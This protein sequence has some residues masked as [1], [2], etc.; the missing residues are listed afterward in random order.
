MTVLSEDQFD[1]AWTDDSDYALLK[2]VARNRGGSVATDLIIQFKEDNPDAISTVKSLYLNVI[3]ADIDFW[4]NQL[5]IKYVF[6]IPHSGTDVLNTSCEAVAS[7]LDNKFE[8]IHHIKHGI[9]RTTDVT[10]SAQTRNRPT[11]TDQQRSLAFNV[12]PF[13]RFYGGKILLIDDVV[14]LGATST[15]CKAILNTE[16]PKAIVYGFFLGRTVQR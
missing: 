10:K 5:N 15:A 2:Y 11:A 16:I 7:A 9:R 12:S 4:K 14:T 1:R 6:C 3:T 8:W 13:Y